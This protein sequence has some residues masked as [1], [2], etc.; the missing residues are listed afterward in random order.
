MANSSEF[1]GIVQ[2]PLHC[3]QYR[4]ELGGRE[5]D[6][7]HKK[8]LVNLFADTSIEHRSSDHH[9]KGYVD[10]TAVPSILHELGLS[11]RQL[12]ETVMHGSYPQLMNHTIVYGQGR[13]RIEAAKEVRPSSLWTVNLSSTDLATIEQKKPIRREVEA[14]QHEK[15]Y[16]DGHIYRKIREYQNE[17]DLESEKIWKRRWGPGKQRYF[18]MIQ[19]RPDIFQALE[20]LTDFPALME[21]LQLG[22][23]HKYFSFHLESYVSRGL[24][25]THYPWSQFPFK[26]FDI[27]TVRIFEGRAPGT[28]HFDRQ[29]I[30][31]AFE[32]GR[33]FRDVRDPQERLDLEQRVCSV[34]NM[35]PSIA[36][37]QKNM[38]YLIIAANII[39]TFLVP[40]ELKKASKKM[41]LVN[42]KKRRT[43]VTLPELLFSCWD[44]STRPVIEVREGEFQPALGP[45]SFELVMYQLL[46]SAI[47]QFGYL[48]PTDAPRG[49]DPSKSAQSCRSLFFRR[50]SLLGLRNALIENETFAPASPFKGDSPGPNTLDCVDY[51]WG[52]PDKHAF[53]QIQEVAFLPQLAECATSSDRVSVC[54]AV[55]NFMESF[56]GPCTFEFDFSQHTLSINSSFSSQTGGDPMRAFSHAGHPANIHSLPPIREEPQSMLESSDIEMEDVQQTLLSGNTQMGATLVQEH[57]FTL[58]SLRPNVPAFT[59][60]EFEATH[61]V[62]TTASSCYSESSGQPCT[63]VDT[64]KVD[65]A[66]VFDIYNGILD[67]PRSTIPSPQ[68][69]V[70]TRPVPFSAS[71]L[72]ESR[73]STLQ[74]FTYGTDEDLT[75]RF[76]TRGS[77][78]RSTIPT[79]PQCFPLTE[80]ASSSSAFSHGV[81][82][83]FQLEGNGAVAFSTDGSPIYSRST[84]PTPSSLQPYHGTPQ[85]EPHWRSNHFSSISNS[86]SNPRSTCPTPRYLSDWNSPTS[87]PVRSF[88]LGNIDAATFKRRSSNWQGFD[89]S[90]DDMVSVDF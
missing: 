11:K 79:P 39:W 44:R 46:L 90:D 37:F 76:L 59:S 66:R 13:H 10:T 63:N 33:V 56:L 35:L 4:S 70:Q 26:S 89:D 29:L 23:Y 6:P 72:G 69:S 41:R 80:H 51:R 42:G 54:F 38:K 81:L 82:G 85:K 55:R 17:G 12:H 68:Y 18:E 5:Y 36:S 28:S 84:I 27:E 31:R 43:L 40:L 83:S 58:T 19:D 22:V 71:P 86:S 2:V 30:C 48:S 8:Y 20:M 32:N 60:P 24:R 52:V 77:D 74:G 9:V 75:D 61:P 49:L 16:S 47:R 45:P 14:F 64:A 21:D 15:R 53:A 87:S 73:C 78:T 7:L 88:G 50:A 65:R 1:L 62:L 67:K 34:P 57:D 25:W 3:F